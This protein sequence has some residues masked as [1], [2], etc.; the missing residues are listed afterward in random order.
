MFLC[1]ALQKLR[2]DDASALPADRVLEMAVKNGAHAMGLEDCD[3]IYA[4]ARA[5]LILIDLMQPNMQPIHNI[6]KNLVYAGN[7]ANVCLT[8]VDGRIRYENGEYR[9]GCEPA[10]IYR[11]CEEITRR[12]TRD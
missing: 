11:R 10:E 9:V 3:G 5:D 7:R 6:A 2:D 1:T 12:L 4:G 8:M